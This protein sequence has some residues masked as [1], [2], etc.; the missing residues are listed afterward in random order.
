MCEL[1]GLSS[2][3]PTDINFSFTGLIE[4]GGRTGPHRDGWGIAYYEGKAASIIQEACPSNQS[5]LAKFIAEYP[6]EASLFIAHIRRA[7]RGKVCLANTHPFRRVL[8][9]RHWVYAH[10]GQLKGVKKAK[11]KHFHPVGTTDSEY[12]F[13][14]LLDQLHERFAKPPTEA[15]LHRFIADRFDELGALGVFNVLL[16][17]GDTL[18]ARCGTKMCLLPVQAPFQKMRLIDR[19]W[20]LDVHEQLAADGQA[21]VIATTPLTTCDNWC[22][23]SKGEMVVLKNGQA[24]DKDGSVWLPN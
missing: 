11:L 15:R 18:Y 20:E 23:F 14:W 4:R 1:F 8:W 16:S 12:A 9:G 19:E 17:N 24:F 22:R 7:N 6:I 5:E 10:N 2:N 3:R 13:C 21:V